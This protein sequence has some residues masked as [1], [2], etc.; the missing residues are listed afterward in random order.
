MSGRWVIE[1][2]ESGCPAATPE[3][4]TCGWRRSAAR[5]VALTMTS[6]PPS[7]SRLQSKRRKGSATSRELRWS[8]RVIGLLMIALSFSKACSRQATASSPKCSTVV[9]KRC[10]CGI[11]IGA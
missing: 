4:N 11:G 3:M 1:A 8:S 7:L 2:G 9:P 10:M 5:S 6:V